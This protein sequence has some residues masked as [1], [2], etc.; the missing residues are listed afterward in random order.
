M[1]IGRM[2]VTLGEHGGP[3][4]TRQDSPSRWAPPG[5]R[6]TLSRYVARLKPRCG[7]LALSVMWYVLTVSQVGAMARFEWNLLSVNIHSKPKSYKVQCLVKMPLAQIAQA[8]R[9]AEA[10]P[11]PGSPRF[12]RASPPSGARQLVKRM[13]LRIGEA[14]K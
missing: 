5:R 9:R 12:G 8:W 13:R 6:L 3:R 7:S 4:K 2:Q 1:T 14:K 10:E 11:A